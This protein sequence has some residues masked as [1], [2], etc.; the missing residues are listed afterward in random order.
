MKGW[1]EQTYKSGCIRPIL[2][3][4]LQRISRAYGIV[5]PITALQ[6]ALSTTSQ[7]FA[8]SI[9]L[10]GYTYY[11]N[12]TKNLG[13]WTDLSDSLIV[14][15]YTDT[16]TTT[17]PLS[18]GGIYLAPGTTV[19]TLGGDDTLSSA[20]SYNYQS[21]SR[22]NFTL[23]SATWLRGTLYMG[24]GKDTISGVISFID[25]HYGCYVPRGDLYGFYNLGGS[26]Y[27]GDDA[28]TIKGSVTVSLY[29][30]Q[31][32]S[33]QQC[34]IVNHGIISTDAGDD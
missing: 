4:P 21:G 16:G 10:Y 25:N 3:D 20:L 1:S 29:G 28:D 13:G 27:L 34:G 26:I 31:T 15:G 9:N 24:T 18:L 17:Q 32:L 7:T 8:Y 22:L 14:S 33:Y 5:Q 6:M 30:R 19:Y 2:A 23:T 12:P 11:L